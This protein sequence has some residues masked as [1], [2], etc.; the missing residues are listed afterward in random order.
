LPSGSWRK[1]LAALPD[2]NGEEVVLEADVMEA[3]GQYL[4]TNAADKSRSRRSA[5]IMSS[6]D[7][8][9]PMRITDVPYIIRRHHDIPAGVFERESIGSASNCIACHTTAEQGI[10]DDDFVTIPD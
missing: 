9:T 8:Q 3:V 1:I 4:E 2:H 5:D 6:L 10:F 7:G